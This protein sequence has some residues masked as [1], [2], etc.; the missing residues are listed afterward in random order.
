MAK[1]IE[2]RTSNSKTPYALGM[3]M[4]GDGQH[5]KPVV[6]SS[7]NPDART[8]TISRLGDTQIFWMDLELG[9]MREA[10]LVRALHADAA[11]LKLFRFKAKLEGY[12]VEQI[13]QALGGRS[14]GHASTALTASQIQAMMDAEEDDAAQAS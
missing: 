6:I 5:R 2:T 3:C 7:G 11:L 10:D 9:R 13:D 8:L 1:F 12:T 4:R 14:A